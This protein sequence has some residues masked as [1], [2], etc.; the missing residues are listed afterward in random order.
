MLKAHLRYVLQ[1]ADERTAYDVVF[2]YSKSISEIAT[3]V[4]RSSP[5][6]FTSSHLIAKCKKTARLL[7][8]AFLCTLSV[9]GLTSPRWRCY[10]FSTSLFSKELFRVK[11]WTFLSHYGTEVSIGHRGWGEWTNSIGR[12]ESNCP[13]ESGVTEPSGLDTGWVTVVQCYVVGWS[14][15]LWGYTHLEAIYYIITYLYYLHGYAA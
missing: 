1:F 3:I 14:S 11:K 12:W 15:D 2:R 5:E 4:T 7:D 13:R 8:N 10:N 9:G 6:L